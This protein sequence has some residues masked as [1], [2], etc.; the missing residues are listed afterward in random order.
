MLMVRY[1]LWIL[2]YHL[3]TIFQQS[4]LGFLKA[5]V[6]WPV[7]L[8]KRFSSNPKD[9]PWMVEK[10]INAVEKGWEE[11]IHPKPPRF[12][13]RALLAIRLEARRLQ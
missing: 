1:H 12:V 3:A 7:F 4:V 5:L 8:L 10:A 13:K 6:L 9:H 11:G 2:V